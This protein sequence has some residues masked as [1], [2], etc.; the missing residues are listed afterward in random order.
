MVLAPS[1]KMPVVMLSGRRELCRLLSHRSL[2]VTAAP[3]GHIGATM[4]EPRIAPIDH[5]INGARV[6]PA[7]CP[8]SQCCQ[9]GGF[10]FQVGSIWTGPSAICAMAA[11]AIGH[12]FRSTFIN[13]LR[14]R[15]YTNN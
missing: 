15:R 13:L 1:S 10:D 7:I 5:L 11:R 9:I 4:G 2:A 3:Y 6:E 12:K 8:L 14:P